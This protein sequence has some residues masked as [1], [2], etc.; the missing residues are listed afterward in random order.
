MERTP[1]ESTDRMLRN[2]GDAYRQFRATS[3]LT[4]MFAG[5][6]E[7]VID[8]LRHR[9]V[10]GTIVLMGSAGLVGLLITF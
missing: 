7:R 1:M 8:L 9:L 6:H 3:M 4:G 2:S 5:A 10:G